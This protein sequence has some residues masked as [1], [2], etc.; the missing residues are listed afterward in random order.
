MLISFLAEAILSTMLCCALTQPWLS[1]M[2]RCLANLRGQA[3]WAFAITPFEFDVFPWIRWS[4]V[5]G[6]FHGFLICCVCFG[7]VR[8]DVSATAFQ[9]M[10]RC[11]VIGSHVEMDYDRR[12]CSLFKSK[13]NL[14]LRTVDRCFFANV[15]LMFPF[16]LM[17]RK[18]ARNIV[19]PG[20]DIQ[21]ELVG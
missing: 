16:F 9:K 5:V 4:V 1:P 20:V 6:E 2:F 11:I 13:A 18:C 14:G 10:W 12:S 19:C 17:M 8:F 7:I 21:I 15:L 3:F